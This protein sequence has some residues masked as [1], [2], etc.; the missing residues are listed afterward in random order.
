MN[1]CEI[2]FQSLDTWGTQLKSKVQCKYEWN[3][4]FLKHF[5]DRPNVYWYA[6]LFYKEKTNLTMKNSGFIRYLI[7]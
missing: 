1:R 7:I 4:H 3:N 2:Q 6:F 5:I